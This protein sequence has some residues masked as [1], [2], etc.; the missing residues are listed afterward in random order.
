MSVSDVPEI[1]VAF[2]RNSFGYTAS[3]LPFPCELLPVFR[4]K[5]IRINTNNWYNSHYG[6]PWAILY[7]QLNSFQLGSTFCGALT[8]VQEMSDY[9]EF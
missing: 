7:V 4:V 9:K 3:A 2:K 5:I 1:H 8:Y 6:V